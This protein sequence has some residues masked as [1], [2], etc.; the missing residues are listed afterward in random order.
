MGDDEAPKALRVLIQRFSGMG[1]HFHVSL[2]PD[3]VAPGVPAE[4]TMKFRKRETAVR[5]ITDAFERD[6]A[7]A[8][9]ELVWD[10]GEQQQWFYGEG[11]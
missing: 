1:T 3:P 11:D 8:G 2:K 4:R 6:Y 10:E 9:Y 7:P 5:W